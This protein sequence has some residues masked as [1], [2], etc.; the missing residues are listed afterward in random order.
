MPP[1]IL[2]ILAALFVMLASL[3]GVVTLWTTLGIWVNEHLSLLVSFSAGV[4][5]VIA[6][7][8]AAETVTHAPS[9]LA[10]VGWI[11]VSSFSVW[12]FFYLVPEMHHHHDTG[13]ESSHSAF[14]VRRIL[15]GDAVHNAA[16]GILLVGA[17]SLGM[18]AGIITTL[19]VFAH[20][21][22]QEASQFF[23]LRQSGYSALRATLLNSAISTT[24][25]LGVLLAYLLSTSV[26]L[27]APLL[28]LATGVYIVII[29]QDFLP[30]SWRELRRQNSYFLHLVWF[31]LGV[32]VIL[33]LGF[34]V[35]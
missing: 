28:G 33:L 3:V 22:V 34:L 23:L 6:A 13:Q 7:L 16:D 29:F 11:F 26:V 4:F 2:V 31:L 25:L 5:L 19:A 21:L 27:V 14:E 17:F 8:L 30:Y 35:E 1:L 18:Q 12:L 20:E 15:L 10:G 32:A 9:A 24:I